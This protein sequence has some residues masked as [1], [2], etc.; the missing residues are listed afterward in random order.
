MTEDAWR[1]APLVP[2]SWRDAP[3]VGATEAE[4]GVAP[5]EPPSGPSALGGATAAATDGALL[6]FGD[7]YLAGLSSI[8]GVQPDGEGGANWFDYSQP[9][10]ERYNTALEQIRREQA[11]FQDERPGL[12]LGAEITGGFLVPGSAGARVVNG[13]RNTG[14]RV[15]RGSGLGLGFGSAY[16]F[17]EGDGL[18]GRLMG[19]A[20]GGIAGAL[21]GG[22]L[23]GIGQGFNRALSALSNRS[24][25]RA[26][27]PSI[28][29]LR[30]AADGLYARAREMGGNLPLSDM[31]RFVSG[32]SRELQEQGFDRD[33]HPRVS[34]VLRRLN[35]ASQGGDPSFEELQILR[36]LIGNAASSTSADERRLAMG[37]MDRLDDTIETMPAGGVLDQARDAWAQLRR[38]E[39]IEGAIERATLVDNF[40]RGLQTQF[41][42]LLRNPRRLRG[43]SQAEIAAI[44]RVANGTG[45]TNGLRALSTLMAPDRLPGLALTG[46]AFFGGAGLA[47]ATIPAFGY[48]ARGLANVL[49]RRNATTARNL[50]ASDEATRRVVEALM[51]Q[52]NYAAPAIAPAMA[53]GDFGVGQAGVR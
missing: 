19:G 20:I 16:G 4:G 1:Q 5:V 10:G 44:R 22:T 3:L 40:A 46:G 29:G 31:R 23:T 41:R 2:P 32:A 14:G 15:L 53:L 52:P 45:A 37:L 43:F 30:E 12:S 50:T 8:L 51:R 34:T 38:V 26:V 42:A 9:I 47:S 27:I 13:A 33:L 36:R 6:G 28:E 7:E 35:Q 39:T 18:E 25:G 11:Q 49:T 21:T 24:E 48:G 17:G